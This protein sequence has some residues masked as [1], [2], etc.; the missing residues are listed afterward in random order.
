MNQLGDRG[1]S[2]QPAKT[3]GSIRAFALKAFAFLLFVMLVVGGVSFTYINSFLSNPGSATARDVEV[4]IQ[5]DTSFSAVS[6]VLKELGAISDVR[7]FILLAEWRKQTGKLRSG[8]YLIN[9]GWMPGR[10]LEHLVS[11]NPVLDRITLPEGL[12]WWETG[13]R[14]E[15]AGL[16]RFEDFEKLVHDEAMLRHWGIPLKTAEGYLFPDTYFIMR[17]LELDEASAKNVIG[18]LI[19]NFW[20]KV[21]VLYDSGKKFTLNERRQ[22]A[23]VIILASIVEKETAV[24]AERA[25]VAGVY[26]NRIRLNMLLQADPTVIYGLGPD[27]TGRLRRAEL[28]DTANPYN[29]YKHPGL[30]PGPICSPGL[31]A[32]KAAMNAEVHDYLYFVA[33]GDGTHQFSKDLETHNR[34]V[35]MFILGKEN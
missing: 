35:R 12:T 28:N 23:S 27:F 21:G 3:P 22:L 25:R 16:V 5:P 13:R 34:A 9:T 17:P 7:R 33:K 15:A 24:P 18:R 26:A 29:T 14:L 31:A 30:P 11:G 20:R 19:D 1:S 32:I 8:R 10:V 2:P 6:V 4:V